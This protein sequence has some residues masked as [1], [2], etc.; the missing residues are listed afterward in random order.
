ME[1]KTLKELRLATGL[2]QT[3]LGELMKIPMRT[4]QNW[5]NGERKMQPYVERWYR[6]ELEEIIASQQ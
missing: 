4:I 1:D 6:K 3:E 2:T 5:E